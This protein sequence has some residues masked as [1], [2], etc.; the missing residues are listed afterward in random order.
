MQ[1]QRSEKK[2]V[3]KKVEMNSSLMLRKNICIPALLLST[4][5]KNYFS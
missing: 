1:M 2:I 5:S 3:G 4:D